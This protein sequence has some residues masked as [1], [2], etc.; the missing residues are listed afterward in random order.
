MYRRF[1]I[2]GDGVTATSVKSVLF[3]LGYDICGLADADV[4][5]VSPGIPPWKYPQTLLPI[6]S[7]I[8]LAYLLF[9]EQKKIP[10]IVAVTGTNGKTTVTDMVEKTL[11][12]TACG[13]IGTPLIEFVLNPPE[14]L[15]VE[16]SSF[17]LETCYQFKPDVAVILNIEPDHLSRHKTMEQYAAVKER[18]IQNMTDKEIIL[19]L[20]G[21]HYIERMVAHSNA[22]VIPFFLKESFDYKQFPFLLGRHNALNV[23]VVFTLQKL[24][25]ADP[26]GVM[27]K[28]QTYHLKPHRLENL[29]VFV[30]RQVYNDSK[31]T[32]P[33]AT[34]AAVEAISDP[35]I[36]ILCGEDKQVD[37]ASFLENIIQKCK[38]VIVF[39]ELKRVLNHSNL[40]GVDTLNEAVKA[41]FSCSEIGDCILFSPSSSSY[42]QFKGYEDRGL[43]FM[44]A[45]ESYEKDHY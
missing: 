32:N 26:F 43:C 34:L 11:G 37:L 42:D 10:F 25:N 20:Q 4:M 38:K 22:K 31:A 24:F 21:D 16:I 19:Y 3:E 5:V 35:K 30:G 12:F 9:K 33:A 27:A 2:L 8:E 36:L 29:G 15:V 40:W 1:F 45:I 13:N 41:A 44:A 17:Q 14:K 28:L 18:L 39:G 6:I 7:E 23:E